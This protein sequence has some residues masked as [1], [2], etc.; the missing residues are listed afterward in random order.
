MYK[1]QT[2]TLL[3]RCKLQT[4]DLTFYKGNLTDTIYFEIFSKPFKGM[5]SVLG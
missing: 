4:I 5:L 3:Q 1:F 2:Q